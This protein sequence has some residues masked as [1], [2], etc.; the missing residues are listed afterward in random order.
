MGRLEDWEIGRLSVSMRIRNFLWILFL[1]ALWGPSFVFIKVAVEEIPPLT[2]VVGRVGVAAILL[3]LILWM[4]GR[5]LAGLGPAWKH[6]AVMA[7][8]HNALPFA[9]FNWGELYIDSALASI[10][11]GTT[12]LFTILLA[13]IFVQDDRLTPNKIVGGVIG[14][15]GL[16]LLVAPSLVNGVQATSWGLLA[17]TVAAASYGVAIVYSRL[18]LRGLPPLVAPTAQ[19]SLA[20][21]YMLPLSLWIEQPFRL[22]APSLQAV[23]ALLVLAVFGT[24]L[25]FVI[26]YRIIERTPATY[27][28]MVTYLVPIFGV[29]LGVL[30][31]GEQLRWNAYLGCILI[32][33]G[34]MVVNNLFR[35]VFW[36]YRVSEALARS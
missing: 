6:L 36:Y 14:F 28:S 21:L 7:L 17:V 35:P 26:Y 16:L 31:L 20:T 3:N 34:V 25:A 5:S 22:P 18:H 13:H 33:S 23:G 27:V 19:L 30:V 32:L 15:G 8:V 2:M 10:L 4:Q 1:A 29:I 11:N 24:A 9:L 12:P